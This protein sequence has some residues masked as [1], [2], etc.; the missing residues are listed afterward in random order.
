MPSNTVDLSEFQGF[1]ARAAVDERFSA[2]RFLAEI[3]AQGVEL[4]LVN[5]LALRFVGIGIVRE[6]LLAIVDRF[7]DFVHHEP[8]FGPGR[9]DTFNPAKALLNWN[10]AAD[11]RARADRRRRL[12]GDLPAGP[13][14]RHAAALGR[15]QHQGLRAQPLR[16]LRHRRH[17]ADPRPRLAETHGGLARHRRAAA[18]QRRLPRPVRRRPRRRGRAGLRPRLRRLPRRLGARLL[19]RVR[20]QGHADRRDRHRP[21]PPRQLHPRPRG[22]PEPALRRLRRR[23][24]PDLPQ[25]RRLRQRAARR[26]LAARALPA[27]RLGADARGAALAARRAPA[28]LPARLRRLRPAR[29]GLR[30]RPRAH[31]PGGP[32]AALLLRHHAPTPPPICPAA[33]PPR[34]APATPAPAA[35]TATAG[36]STAPPCR[37]RRSGR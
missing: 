17:A 13:E 15:Q 7:D 20:R 3:D 12:P 31:R 4:D 5:R 11:P 34:T 9:F 24:L 6:R 8:T 27:Q 2:D 22:Q 16:R 23:A 32:A 19:R 37:R 21:R 25:D 36:I 14:D 18:L 26:P 28:R 1:L 33:V 10:F 29:H 35:A 30:Q